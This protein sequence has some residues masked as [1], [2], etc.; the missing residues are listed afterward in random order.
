MPSYKITTPNGTFKVTAPNELSDEEIQSYIRQSTGEEEPAAP[1]PEAPKPTTLGQALAPSL[2][3]AIGT[4]YEPRPYTENIAAPDVRSQPVTERARAKPT[5]GDL[6][7]NE[8]PEGFFQEKRGMIKVPAVD[9][10]TSQKV[11]DATLGAASDIPTIA[12]RAAGSAASKA[13]LKSATGGK[14][15]GFLEGMADPETG[16]LRAGREYASKALKQQLA[17]LKD[18]D[19]TYW[20][21]VGDSF[22]AELAATG[23]LTAS[24]LEDPVAMAG[25][26]S[27]ITKQALKGAGKFVSKVKTKVAEKTKLPQEALERAAKDTKAVEAAAGTEEALTYQLG[28]DITKIRQEVRTGA[29]ATEK[30]PGHL[31]IEG[32]QAA[33]M[34]KHDKAVADLMADYESRAAKQEAGYNADVLAREKINTEAVTA[35]EKETATQKTALESGVL[36][37]RPGQPIA[38]ASQI[39]PYESGKR[40]ETAASEARKAIG[41]KYRDRLDQEFYKSGIA[42]IKLPAKSKTGEAAKALTGSSKAVRVNPMQEFIDD[43]LT[44]IGY[45]KAKGYQQMEGASKNAVEWLLKKREGAGNIK[46]LDQ[47]LKFRKNFQDDLFASSSGQNPLFPRKGQ[48][49]NDYRFLNS[50]YH[51]SNN[52]IAEIPAK[53]LGKKEGETWKRV[54]SELRKDYAEPESVIE[55][56]VSGIGKAAD[57]EDFMTRIKDVPVD[58]I[59]AMRTAATKHKE[60]QPLV[61]EVEQMAFDN[62]VRTSLDPANGNAFSPEKMI[63]LFNTEDKARLKALLGPERVARIQQAISRYKLPEKPTALPRVEKP[64]A[65]PKPTLP[66]KPDWKML[67]NEPA[68]KELAGAS[69]EVNQG[70]IRSNI[71]NMGQDPKVFA[72]RE[73]EFLDNALG[74]KGKD[75]YTEK[76]LDAWAANKLGI[77]PKVKK[78]PKENPLPT[79]YATASK[80]TGAGAGAA[81]GAVAGN[82]LGGPVM[83]ALL[84][85]LGLKA[86]QAAGAQALSPA[87]AVAVYKA[88][89]TLAGI[90]PTP[91]TI[92]LLKAIRNAGTASTAARLTAELEREIGS[93]PE[94]QIEAVGTP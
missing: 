64:G 45:D 87:T 79:G 19:R 88:M 94:K 31:G 41:T 3:K 52:L 89:N 50:V 18:E 21:K 76:V 14:D 25:I 42:D 86:G 22:V 48:A 46:T 10:P 81:I 27:Q 91:R 11:R 28:D 4:E 47:A 51:E 71:A 29:P 82:A 54:W 15:V 73:L 40:L 5:M 6:R 65:I 55:D 57:P 24:I 35:F 30:S 1:A 20:Q 66:D 38:S 34:T 58:D 9:S 78:L 37:Q 83:G 39:S 36:S 92:A 7:A 85:T 70:K 23:Y 62:M 56:L 84:S 74:L 2:S 72:M 26:V 63:R 93:V 43:A 61:S 12:V 68:Y 33:D 90:K 13:G 60:I 8:S 32:E 77:D 16:V 67:S 75:S 69:Q 59:T 17:D 80:M 44:R 53:Q 49:A